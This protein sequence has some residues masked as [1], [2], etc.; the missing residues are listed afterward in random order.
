M[1]LQTLR[2]ALK[3]RGSLSIYNLERTSS[4]GALQTAGNSSAVQM[5]AVGFAVTVWGLPNAT[6]VSASRLSSAKIFA[7][8][9]NAEMAESLGAT[10][11]TAMTAWNVANLVNVPAPLLA[12]ARPVAQ[13]VAVD[14]AEAAIT[15]PAST[16]I[17]PAHLTVRARLAAP[18]GAAAAAGSALELHAFQ[19]PNPWTSANSTLGLRRLRG[20]PLLPVVTFRSSLHPGN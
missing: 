10:A 16:E 18:T 1:F 20:F 14:S 8:A 15:V 19:P 6:R 4:P 3:D 17:V 12:R 7:G 9:N 13:M 5:A 11:D 2:K